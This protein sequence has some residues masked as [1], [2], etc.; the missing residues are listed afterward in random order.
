METDSVCW[1]EVAARVTSDLLFVLQVSAVWFSTEGPAGTDFSLF[2][3][4]VSSSSSSS[5]ALRLSFSFQ[6]GVP[7]GQRPAR[8]QHQQLRLDPPFSSPLLPPSSSSSLHSSPP[9]VL[10]PSPCWR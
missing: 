2:V 1:T 10:P 8:R 7:S 3:F 5:S 4:H 6:G 9:A